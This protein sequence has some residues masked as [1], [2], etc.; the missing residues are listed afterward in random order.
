MENFFD[1]LIQYKKEITSFVGV[2]LIIFFVASCYG[3]W[4]EIWY[5]FG[6]NLYHLFAA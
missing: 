3:K 5:E 2:V 6:R 1:I 4:N